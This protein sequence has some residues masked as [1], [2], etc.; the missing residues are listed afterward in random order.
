[1]YYEDVDLAKRYLLA[2][3]PIR[4]ATGLIIHH[5]GEASAEIPL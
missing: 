2:G 3:Y 1:M 5:V 4:V